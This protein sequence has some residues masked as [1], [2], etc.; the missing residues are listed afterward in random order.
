MIIII[1]KLP[2]KESFLRRSRGSGSRTFQK[3]E[4]DS[5]KQNRFSRAKFKLYVKNL[6]S[7]FQ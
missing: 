7:F 5:R 3:F 6:I 2:R 1:L 4:M